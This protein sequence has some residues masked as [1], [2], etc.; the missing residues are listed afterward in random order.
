MLYDEGFCC[1]LDF[2]PP[3]FFFNCL[4]DVLFIQMLLAVYEL[5]HDEAMIL[6]LSGIVIEQS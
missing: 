2:G 3:K 5:F 4:R 1:L 6:I